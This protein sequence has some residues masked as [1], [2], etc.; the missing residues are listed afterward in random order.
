MRFATNL[1]YAL[2]FI[3]AGSIASSLFCLLAFK[4]SALGYDAININ[5]LDGVDYVV[6]ERLQF[7]TFFVAWAISTLW[8]FWKKYKIDYRWDSGKYLYCL[9]CGYDLRGNQGNMCPECGYTMTS[10]Q[11]EELST[12]D[13]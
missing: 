12:K 13:A 4:L 8:L 11:Q 2:I 7:A 5:F 1:G 3:V 9:R 10:I 6:V